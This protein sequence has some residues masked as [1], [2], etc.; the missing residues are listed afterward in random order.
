MDKKYYWL[1]FSL[2]GEA[3]GVCVIEEKSGPLAIEKAKKLN[4]IPKHDDVEVF[5]L[6]EPEIEC[7][8]FFTVKEMKDRSYEPVEQW[9]DKTKTIDDAYK[10]LKDDENN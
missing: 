6:A 10:L 4:L 8:K 1:S 3:E 5:E 2:D 7:D 9:T